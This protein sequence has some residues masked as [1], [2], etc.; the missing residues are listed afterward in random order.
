MQMTC[1]A[2]HENLK[3][4]RDAHL[5]DNKHDKQWKCMNQSCIQ[6]IMW[7][8]T[9]PVKDKACLPNLSTVRHL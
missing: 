7:T 9:H 1:S 4:Y 8:A 5:Q 2:S 6:F 3:K